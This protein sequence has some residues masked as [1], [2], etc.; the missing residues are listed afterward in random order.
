MDLVAAGLVAAALAFAMS[1]F[2]VSIACDYRYLDFLDLAA[3]A[4]ALAAAAR[5]N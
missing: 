5:K 2:V 1:F 4:G 3:M